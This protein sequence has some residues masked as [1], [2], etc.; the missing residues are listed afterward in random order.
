MWVLREAWVL[1]RQMHRASRG[2]RWCYAKGLVFHL[3]RSRAHS[4]CLSL[5]VLLRHILAQDGILDMDQLGG[6]YL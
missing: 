3:V 2:L 6:S 5:R 4:G 1:G